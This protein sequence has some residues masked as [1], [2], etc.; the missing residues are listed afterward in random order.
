MV[1]GA[2]L[3]AE[4]NI[5]DQAFIFLGYPIAIAVEINGKMW[6][7]EYIEAVVILYKSAWRIKGGNKFGNFIGP[8]IPILVP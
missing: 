3:K 7:V 5:V 1:G 4:G 8:A 6:G 2:L